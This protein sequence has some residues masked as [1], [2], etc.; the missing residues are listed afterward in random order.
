MQSSLKEMLRAIFTNASKVQ[1]SIERL[2]A[3]SNEINLATQVQA[4]PSGTRARRSAMSRRAS[5]W[6]TDL[7]GPP[8]TARMK[9]P[10][11]PTTVPLSRRQGGA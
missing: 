10:G 6:S 3:E 9:S 1:A 2:S 4:A 7:S 11:A 8:K 5:K